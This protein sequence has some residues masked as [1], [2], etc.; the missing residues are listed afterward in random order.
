MSE[1]IAQKELFLSLS[2]MEKITSLYNRAVSTGRPVAIWSLPGSKDFQVIID[3]SEF[4]TS[5]RIE[6]EKSLPGFIYSPFKSEEGKES[7]FLRADLIYSSKTDALSISPTVKDEVSVSVDNFLQSLEERSKPSNEEAE[8]PIS[9]QKSNDYI[10]LVKNGIS[11]IKA[12]AYDKLV[13][14]RNKKITLP[15]G[16]D[17][18]RTLTQLRDAYQNAFCY[19]LYTKQ[20]GSWMAAT[21]ETLISLTEDTFETVSLAGTS[22]LAPEQSLNTVS[23]TQKE[24]E[25]QAMVSRYIINCFKKIRLREFKE[26]GPKTVKAGNLAHLKT[27]FTVQYKN[28]NFEE[29]GTVMLEL[30]HPTSAVCGMPLEGARQFIRDREGFDRSLFAGF[31]GPVNVNETTNIFVNLRTMRFTRQEAVLYAGAGITADSD[32]EKELMETEMKMNTLLNIIQS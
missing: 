19:L 14:S 21:P 30:L 2:R 6:V 4:S 5:G 20:F 29:L 23:W 28:I 13:L 16:F 27:W 25:E 3:F 18:I 1:K 12:G 8:P 32:P 11:A 22:V 24:I 9:F 15:H 17:P 10:E 7:Y 31:L 26:S